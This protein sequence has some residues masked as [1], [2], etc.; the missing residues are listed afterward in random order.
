MSEI[1]AKW[2]GERLTDAMTRAGVSD[3]DLAQALGVTSRSVYGWKRGSEPRGQQTLRG[4]A[5]AVGVQ[6]EDLFTYEAP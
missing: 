4:I 2:A 5:C 1:V 3:T 6:V